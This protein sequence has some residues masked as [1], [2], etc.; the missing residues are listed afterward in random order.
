MAND[1][2]RYLVDPSLYY[3]NIDDFVY[4]VN[5]FETVL[6]P[7]KL[8]S[9]FH[10]IKDISIE[11]LYDDSGKIKPAGSKSTADDLSTIYGTVES[12]AGVDGNND[13]TSVLPTVKDPKRVRLTNDIR[14]EAS[15][16]KY[17]G[18]SDFPDDNKK[19]GVVAYFEV[20]KE[21][22]LSI[23]D[24]TNSWDP[25]FYTYD[26]RSKHWNYLGK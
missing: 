2:S 23:D 17:H 18:F 7:S 13:A 5:I 4:T 20:P 26:A 1:P 11:Q 22:D 14:R 6:D 8:S 19:H 21:G 25:G 9:Y 15:K 3:R 10:D 16:V 12:W 24:W